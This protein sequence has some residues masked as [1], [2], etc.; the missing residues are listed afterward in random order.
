[1]QTARE[2]G[3]G[4]RAVVTMGAGTGGTGVEGVVALRG[5]GRTVS[6]ASTVIGWAGIRAPKNAPESLGAAA[7]KLTCA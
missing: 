3:W 5:A 2:V 6:R 1:M 4:E 7:P